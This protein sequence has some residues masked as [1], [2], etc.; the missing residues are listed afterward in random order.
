MLLALLRALIVA[1]V[2]L[3]LHSTPQISIRVSRIKITTSE[4]L[5]ACSEERVH[6]T[7][8]CIILL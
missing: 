3:V 4:D 5:L 7:Y 8:S 6:H 2:S 1:G